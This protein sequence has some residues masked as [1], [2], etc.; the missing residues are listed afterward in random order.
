MYFYTT[1]LSKYCFYDVSFYFLHI[2]P[3][4]SIIQYHFPFFF[5]FFKN[6]IFRVNI[7]EKIFGKEQRSENTTLPALERGNW[8]II[9][10]E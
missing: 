6:Y 7:E 9:I 10:S 8:R 1:N 5:S 4:K 2:Y 3:G